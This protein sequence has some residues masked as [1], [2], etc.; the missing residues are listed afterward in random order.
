MQIG[1]QSSDAIEL[2]KNKNQLWYSCERGA[3]ILLVDQ[4]GRE[5][6]KPYEGSYPTDIDNAS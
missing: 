5:Y 2:H 3:N 1:K 4:N 6:R